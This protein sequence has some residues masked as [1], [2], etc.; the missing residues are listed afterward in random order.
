MENEKKINNRK[1]WK[2][3]KISKQDWKSGRWKIE[4]VW[5]Y[6]KTLFIWQSDITT[7]SLQKPI[8]EGGK[9]VY[10]F[11]FPSISFSKHEICSRR[12][13]NF[14]LDEVKVEDNRKKVEHWITHSAWNSEWSKEGS[15]ITQKHE[16]SDTRDLFT[17]KRHTLIFAVKIFKRRKIQFIFP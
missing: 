7:K 12:R 13:E 1:S 16:A 8:A 17:W 6:L 14:L 3:W 9:D 2:K 5:I 15:K 10:R 4:K 11:I